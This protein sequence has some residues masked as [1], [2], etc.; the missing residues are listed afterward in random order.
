M[1]PE[2]EMSPAREI[3]RVPELIP[4]SST[5]VLVLLVIAEL[6]AV[7]AVVAIWRERGR[8]WA[9]KLL[10]TF[11]TLV[12]VVGLVAFFVWRDPPPPNDPIDRP[13]KRYSVG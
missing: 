12:P 10:W 4:V 11:V 9:A 1:S 8:S 7:A 13:P 5:V 6:A 2:R 3:G